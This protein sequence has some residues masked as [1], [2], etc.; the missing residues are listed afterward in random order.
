MKAKV[1]KIEA[2]FVGLKENDYSLHDKNGIQYY[3]HQKDLPLLIQQ[4]QKSR[5]LGYTYRFT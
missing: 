2:H 3:K 5:V 1:E 4:G